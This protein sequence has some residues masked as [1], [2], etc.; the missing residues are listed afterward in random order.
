LVWAFVRREARR[1]GTIDLL[2]GT[3]AV[4]EERTLDFE[5]CTCE[6]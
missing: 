6:F 3:R 5:I 2:T 4:L 1:Y